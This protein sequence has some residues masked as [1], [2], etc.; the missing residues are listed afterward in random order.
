MAPTAAAKLAADAKAKDARAVGKN[1]PQAQASPVPAPNI[2]I[3]MLG[4]SPPQRLTGAAPQVQQGQAV[5]VK[6][7]APQPPPQVD[8]G[9]A[10]VAGADAEEPPAKKVKTDKQLINDARSYFKRVSDGH[11]SKMSHQQKDEANCAL[12]EF[13]SCNAAGKISF[14]QRFAETKKSK[15][16]AWTRNFKETFMST[17]TEK[18]KLHEKRLN[19][20][21]CTCPHWGRGKGGAGVIKGEAELQQ[22]RPITLA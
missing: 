17:S 10:T 3:K 2:L 15:D 6:S 20:K 19:R 13:N 4:G 7:A 8:A 5:C 12:K 11:F 9:E 16:F 18:A 14:A 21:A 1:T 22:A